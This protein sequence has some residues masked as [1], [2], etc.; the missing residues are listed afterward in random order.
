MR[1][2]FA[3]YAFVYHTV[4]LYSRLVLRKYTYTTDI[5]PRMKEPIIAVANHTTEADMFMTVRAFPKCMYYVCGEHL[6]RSKWGKAITRLCDPI[7]APRGG[8]MIGVIKEVY[9]RIKEGYSIMIFPEGCR[10]FNGE[11]LRIDAATAKFIKK[12]GAGLVTYHTSGGYFVAPRWSYV[13]R[14]GH[15]EGKIKGVYTAEQ[16]KELSVEEVQEIINRD[17]YENAHE[18]QRKLAKPYDYTCDAL[19]EGL[20]N[21][22]VICPQ[23]GAY[24]TL[25][26]HK[27]S[28]HCTKCGH[29]GIYQPSGF[30]SGEGLKFDNV[31]DWGN[32]QEERFDADQAGKTMDEVLFTETD[33]ALYQILPDH[34]R[35]EYGMGSLTA[36]REGMTW[37]A[38]DS[39]APVPVM[40]FDYKRI[41]AESL[42]Y[43][44]KSMLFTDDTGYYGLTGEHFHAWK[45]D[46]LYNTCAR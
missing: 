1:K 19:A 31:Y 21:Y 43:Y 39:A 2:G 46:R 29:G 16:L 28:F 18:T 40:H 14:K 34:S 44:G 9:K 25:E 36:T 32:W 26:S 5:A 41:Q 13:F 22:L 27:D 12:S 7:Y 3:R 35:K 42:L 24:D 33:I 30:F 6:T 20:E 17:L 10:S 37:T 4:R 15:C 8:S 23:C 38:D 11:T 45:E